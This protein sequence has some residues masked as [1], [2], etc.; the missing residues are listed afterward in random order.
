ML[1]IRRAES[2]RPGG[3]ALELLRPLQGGTN[4]IF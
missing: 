1:P 4:V 2:I 3:R